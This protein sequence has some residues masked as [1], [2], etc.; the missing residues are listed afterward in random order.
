MVLGGLLVEAARLG[1]GAVGWGFPPLPGAG[2]WAGVAS[3][4][5]HV[6]VEIRIELEQEL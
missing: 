1:T 5:G 6:G 2:V 4:P 3:A